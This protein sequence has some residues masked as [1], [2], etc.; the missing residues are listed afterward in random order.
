MAQFWVDKYRGNT[1]TYGQ[2]I[3]LVKY[4]DI[5]ST[6]PKFTKCLQ[7][8]YSKLFPRGVTWHGNS[9]FAK[10]NDFILIN[11]SLELVFEYA[12]RAYFPDKPSRAES[13]FAFHSLQDI[14]VFANVINIDASNHTIW[15]VECDNYHRGN[16]RLLSLGSN[17][18]TSYY[19]HEYWSGS[20]GGDCE[21]LWEYLL[22][23][24]VHILR[25]IYTE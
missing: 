12:K 18:V 7:S 24:P 20:A 13:F 25:K 4:N 10:C 9:Y 1:L 22:T 2:T 5:S 14:F 23:P 17:L 19:A 3:D 16:M 8:H 21:A 15:E 11:P 6:D